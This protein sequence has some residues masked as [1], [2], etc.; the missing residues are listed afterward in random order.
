[1]NLMREVRFCLGADA[2]ATPVLNSWAGWP[3]TDRIAP[4]LVLR[5]TVSGPVDPR[6]GYMCNITLIDRLLRERAIPH[7]Q[8]SWQGSAGRGCPAA[9]VVREVWDLISG[10]TPPRTT[11]ESLRLDV[12]PFLRWTAARGE[13]PMIVMT[14]SFE[15]AASH[16][17]YCHDLADQENR[18]I[19]GK[20][21][22]PNGH[23]HNYVLEVSVR[24]EPGTQCGTIMNHAAF[25]QTVRQ[26]VI[27]RFDHKHLNSD[28]PDFAERNPTVENI[29]RVIWDL[30]EGHFDPAALHSV[31]VWETPKTYAE[32][33]G[34]GVASA[35]GP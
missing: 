5:A 19:F 13:L 11:L 1:M 14:E 22:N 31:R 2:V 4:H 9:A 6:T 30:L 21:S 33:C 27:E 3:A 29:T 15:F 12:S 10:R 17:L 34:P 16:R 23:G 26:R 28:C 24:G 35:P 7:L 18:E 25:Q 8:L 20:C 32:Y